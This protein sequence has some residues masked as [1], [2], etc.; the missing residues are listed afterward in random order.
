MDFL[1]PHR[2]RLVILS[3][4]S[5][6][7]NNS[8]QEENFNKHYQRPTFID[9]DDELANTHL[10]EKF[11]SD[12]FDEN[13]Y[14]DTHEKLESEQPT[15]LI[16]TPSMT[17]ANN[18]AYNARKVAQTT[19]ASK[20]ENSEKQMNGENGSLNTLGNNR[21][22]HTRPRNRNNGTTS[23]RANRKHS[24]ANKER[25]NDNGGIGVRKEKT[26]RRGDDLR[27]NF[28]TKVNNR[29]ELDRGNG[30]F[31]EKNG[32]IRQPKKPSMKVDSTD[33]L[34]PDSDYEWNS[35]RKPAIRD[36]NIHVVKPVEGSFVPSTP[37][38][39][40]SKIIEIKPS[41]S[42]TSKR[43]R[44]SSNAIETRMQIEDDQIED[45]FGNM[46]DEDVP[47]PRIYVNFEN[48]EPVES[49]DNLLK[50]APDAV[51][52]AL[53]GTNVPAN[54]TPITTATKQLH[55][56]AGCLQHYLNVNKEIG[57]CNCAFILLQISITH[58][59]VSKIIPRTAEMH[60]PPPFAAILMNMSFFHSFTDTK[61]WMAMLP[62]YEFMNFVF[63][64]IVWSSRYPS[65]YW[66]T[67]KAF[68]LIFSIQMIANSIDLLLVFAGVSV[69]YKLQVAGQKLPLQVSFP[70]NFHKSHNVSAYIV[71][72]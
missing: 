51:A 68:S 17:T 16:T 28:E 42:R 25:P 53:I 48:T 39:T 56:F 65:V 47:E 8:A 66:N 69:I 71:I 54:V 11:H 49:D 35:N 10:I 64:L 21:K 26:N 22:Q 59:S 31:G 2:D 36:S 58:H 40:D 32:V 60:T 41:T 43:Y 23:G 61:S 63:A 57:M 13:D 62:S 50:P 9:K 5:P 37:F 44:R 12:T 38:S 18:E 55:G 20:T 30:E 33:E 3:F 70:M 4:T 67:S 72:C 29:L 34:P 1:V 7:R 14:F 45:E 27:E 52:A 15:F 6:Y 46:E 19:A 24:N